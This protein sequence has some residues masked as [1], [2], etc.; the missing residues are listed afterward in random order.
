MLRQ[1]YMLN[2]NQAMTTVQMH[3]HSGYVRFRDRSFDM[4]LSLK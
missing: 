1:S 3:F 2:V 4:M